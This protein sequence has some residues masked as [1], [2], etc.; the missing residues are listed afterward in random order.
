[1]VIEIDGK[2]F[3]GNWNG[4][5]KDIRELEILKMLAKEIFNSA[6]ELCNEQAFVML[7]I[8]GGMIRVYS[9]FETKIGAEFF[10]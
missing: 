10:R 9:Q 8:N 5:V 7:D 1:M 4:A 6:Y 2:Q 3:S